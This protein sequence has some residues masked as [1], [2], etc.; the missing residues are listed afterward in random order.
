MK[1]EKTKVKNVNHKFRSRNKTG[2][3]KHH[4]FTQV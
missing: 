4:D 3:L 1:V 2:L